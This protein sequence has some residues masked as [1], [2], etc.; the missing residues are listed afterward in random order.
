MKGLNLG[1]MIRRRRLDL[2]LSASALAGIL[3][4]SLRTVRYWEAGRVIPRKASLRALYRLH[5]G[6]HLQKITKKA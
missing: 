3:G 1:A 2:G 4:V 5:S 6:C